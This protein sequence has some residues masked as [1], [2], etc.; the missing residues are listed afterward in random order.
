ML[1]EW[2]KSAEEDVREGLRMKWKVSGRMAGIGGCDVEEKGLGEKGV[3]GYL[4]G[5]QRV[6]VLE[7]DC[8]CLC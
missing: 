5:S 3:Y 6:S 1:G 4:L 7:K 2:D 8:V